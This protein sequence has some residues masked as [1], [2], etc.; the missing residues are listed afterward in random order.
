MFLSLLFK[1]AHEA[2]LLTYALLGAWLV[3]W[4]L[5]E[6]LALSTGW[7]WIMPTQKINP[8]Y[9]A[10]CLPY[11][12]PGDVSLGDFLLFAAV[13]GLISLFLIVVTV[14]K[15]RAVCTHESVKKVKQE[16]PPARTGILWRVLQRNVP[17]ITPSVDSN[18]VA[19]REWNRGGSSPARR[20]LTGLFIS[21]S[22]IFSVLAILGPGGEFGPM[23]NGCQVAIGL[24]FLGVWSATSLAEE[25]VRGSLDLLMCTPLSTPEIVKGKW[26]GSFR[27]A[28][29]LAILPC[30]VIGSNAFID[31]QSIIAA[32]L[33]M[34]LYVLCAGAAVTSLGI[35]MA[36]W[37]PRPGRAVAFT[38]AIDILATVGWPFVVAIEAQPARDKLAMASPFFWA[39]RMSY[40]F[41]SPQPDKYTDWALLWTG[42][43]FLT[44]LAACSIAAP[45]D[46][47]DLA[48]WAA[49]EDVINQLSR[50]PR[51]PTGGWP[52]TLFRGGH[53]AYSPHARV[54]LGFCFAA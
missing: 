6:V 47:F 7:F 29:L 22:V 36:T 27:A 21:I 4:P 54:R 48:A 39:G 19:W 45:S 41:G 52:R 34:L 24:L 2:L 40:Q 13:T 17:W 15:V 30:F 53:V 50:P 51:L 38:V 46:D 11:W 1:K 9:M 44:A 43:A 26:L 3:T 8:F 35:L 31:D 10:L 20:V 42:V 25:R 33:L 18:P 49:L 14:L 37:V 5:C 23:V 16:R 32:S 12:H 28:P